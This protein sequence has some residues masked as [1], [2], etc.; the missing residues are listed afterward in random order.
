[1]SL[2][3]GAGTDTLRIATGANFY[4]LSAQVTA[5]AGGNITQTI[6]SVKGFE[7]IE[8]QEADGARAAATPLDVTAATFL[9]NGSDATVAVRY[10]IDTATGNRYTIDDVAVASRLHL[11]DN[12]GNSATARNVDLSKVKFDITRLVDQFIVETGNASDVITLP[13]TLAGQVLRVDGNGGNDRIIV[14]DGPGVTN[15]ILGAGSDTV[16]LTKSTSANV[17]AFANGTGVAATAAQVTGTHTI[18]G[19]KPQTLLDVEAFATG[20]VAFGGAAGLGVLGT[21]S[22]LTTNL[23]TV[24]STTGAAANLTLEGGAVITDFTSAEQLAN[25]LGERYTTAATN[26]QVFAINNTNAGVNKSYIWLYSELVANPIVGNAA[27]D[28]VFNA[29]NF[30]LLA[31]VENGGVGL[32]TANFATIDQA[33]LIGGGATA[34][35]NIWVA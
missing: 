10:G 21:Q 29:D 32:T 20:G 4:G 35:A 15:I 5:A 27:A 23:V 31:V 1:V 7:R 2:D 25:Y 6:S 17:I 22:A 34:T 18:T 24:I 3:A 30:A 33:T 13:T 12:L 11:N 16:D 8:L 19:W 9:L 28:A 14:G 26:E